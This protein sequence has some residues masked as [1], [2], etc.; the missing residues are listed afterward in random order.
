MNYQVCYR[1]I[2][3]K[4]NDTWYAHFFEKR[5]DALRYYNDK[6]NDKLSKREVKILTIGGKLC[7]VHGKAA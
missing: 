5:E 7:Q 4:D 2:C 6:K 1:F 3:D